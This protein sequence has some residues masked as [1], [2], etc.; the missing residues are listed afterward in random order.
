LTACWSTSRTGKMHPYYLC[1]SRNCPSRRKSIP[2]ERLEGVI[3]ALLKSLQPTQ[4]LFALVKDMFRKA[5]D[6][7]QAHQEATLV[8]AKR[9][10]AKLDELIEQLVDRMVETKSA[11]ALTAFENGLA[12]L[13]REKLV[14]SEKL[15]D[16]G[17]PQRSFDELF[18]LAMGFLSNPWKLWA[19]ERLD[20]KRTALKL[21]FQSRL[22]YHREHGVRTAK[23]TL[24]FNMLGGMTMSKSEMARLRC[25]GIIRERPPPLRS[26]P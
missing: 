14:A 23:T 6:M 18:E 10:L 22:E 19:S 26:R 4:A 25:D 3:D 2:R 13:E 5:W 7:R 17:R 16:K 21:V 12:K 9:E 1:H 8:L 20:D 11:A 15:T 24:P